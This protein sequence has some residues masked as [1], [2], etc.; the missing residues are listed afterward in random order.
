MHAAVLPTMRTHRA[1]HRTV[2]NLLRGRKREANS[3]AH[4]SHRRAGCPTCDALV[5]P[6]VT[7]PRPPAARPALL[8]HRVGI[9]R[10][11]AASG[12]TC[13]SAPLI[14]P[15]K[16]ASI[17]NTHRRAKVTCRRAGAKRGGSN[18]CWACSGRRA[19]HRAIRFMRGRDRIE[20]PASPGPGTLERRCIFS[21]TRTIKRSR[22]DLN[23]SM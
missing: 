11:G 18:V 8:T 9:P 4:R 3:T 20:L 17:D 1:D 7:P 12:V 5:W 19:D 13:G 21:V 6:G 15:H 14:M 22:P 2:A 10:L 23:E 16:P